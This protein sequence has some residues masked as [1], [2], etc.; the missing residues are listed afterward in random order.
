M[1][2]LK[3]SDGLY[4]DSLELKE[5]LLNYKD[6]KV[7]SVEQFSPIP[8]MKKFKEVFLNNHE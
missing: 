2:L 4:S 3:N 6:I 5:K 8:V 7:P 1:Y